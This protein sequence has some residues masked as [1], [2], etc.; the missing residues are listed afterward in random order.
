[1]LENKENVQNTLSDNTSSISISALLAS[2]KEYYSVLLAL[3]ILFSTVIILAY[4]SKNNFVPNITLSDSYFYISISIASVFIYLGLLVYSVYSS[5]WLVMLLA[6]LAKRCSKKKQSTR[7]LRKFL[8][9]KINFFFSLLTFTF[10]VLLV[11][12]Q[13]ANEVAMLIMGFFVAGFLIV[14]VFGT[15]VRVGRADNLNAKSKKIMLAVA[16]L[17]PFVIAGASKPFLE[18]IFRL[19]SVRQ[20]NVMLI[21]TEKNYDLVRSAATVAQ[22]K[23]DHL[24]TCSCEELIKNATLIWHGIGS[25]SLVLIKDGDRKI[26]V[27]LESNGIYPINLFDKSSASESHKTEKVLP[28]SCDS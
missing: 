27:E 28:I 25:K 12:D 5:I 3:G 19:L 2:V 24:K 9:G 13:R 14:S 16:L 21:L 23:V 4:S 20:E 1:M 18:A 8:D 26:S 6:F 11:I 15:T 22:I 7:Q 17:F 10:F